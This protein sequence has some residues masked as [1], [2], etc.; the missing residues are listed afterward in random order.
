MI[1]KLYELFRK[2]YI[3][4]SESGQYSGGYW[5]N[6][7]REYAAKQASGV[8]GSIVEL[9]CGEGL[10]LKEISRSNPEAEIV[11]VDS[12]EEILKKAKAR[13]VNEKN[14]KLINADAVKDD[15]GK[16]KYDFC[17][18]L[19]IVIN[20]RSKEEV[21]ELML[22]AF[23]ILKNSGKFVFDI[24]NSSNLLVRLKYRYVKLYDPGIKVP[25]NSYSESEID[26]MLLSAGFNRIAKKYQGF[27][28][29][30]HSPVIIY[31]A[32]K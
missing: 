25:V 32:E 20:L 6:L 16:E 8:K 11:G 3:K 30:R 14:I 18:C 21:S 22:Q 12:W 26:G 24:R 4:K 5:P 2:L 9:G 29:N 15:L 27:P 10:F 31:Q 23:R 28:C 19:N 1:N 17:F 13:L 7:V